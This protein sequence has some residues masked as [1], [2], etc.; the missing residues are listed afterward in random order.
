MVILL[1]RSLLGNAMSVAFLCDLL[2]VSRKDLAAQQLTE[3]AV[4]RV[5]D[6]LVASIGD[7]ARGHG[8]DETFPILYDLDVM[9]DED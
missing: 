6:I 7:N 5:D 4:Y 8:H 1:H 3:A 9:D 2:L